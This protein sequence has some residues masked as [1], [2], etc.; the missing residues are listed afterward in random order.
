MY[1]LTTW[2]FYDLVTKETMCSKAMDN[3][4]YFKTGKVLQQLLLND[5]LGFQKAA[6]FTDL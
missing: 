1:Y 3:D 2:K 5:V 6:L 4:Y